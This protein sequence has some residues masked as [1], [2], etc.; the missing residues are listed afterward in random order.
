MQHMYILK[1]HSYK[2]SV[3]RCVNYFYHTHTHTHIYIYIYFFFL[4]CHNGMTYFIWWRC[5]IYIYIYI[6]IKL[7]FWIKLRLLN[8]IKWG[9]CEYKWFH[10]IP[11]TKH[12]FLSPPAK[13]FHCTKCGQL[14]EYTDSAHIEGEQMLSSKPSD[15]SIVVSTHSSSDVSIRWVLTHLVMLVYVEYSLI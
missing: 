11:F 6:Y 1:I 4:W 3:K 13:C 8:T 12:L 9:W 10:N 5:Y 7:K 2:H 14:S 15:V